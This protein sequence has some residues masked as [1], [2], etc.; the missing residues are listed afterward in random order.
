M[1]S[2]VVGL[3]L[4]GSPRRN[5]G[6][7]VLTGATSTRLKVLHEDDEIL[8]Q[9]MDARPSLVSIDAPL[10][11]PRGRASLEARGP[12]HLRE[13]D[14]ELL[15]RRIPFFPLTLGPM[16]MLTAR[17][18]RLAAEFT[19]RGMPVI[20]SYPGGAQ[21]A[22]GMPRKHAGIEPLRAA[23]KRYGMRGDVE[24]PEI[25]HDELDAVTCALVGR[26]FVLGRA[27]SIG[28]PGEGIMVLPRRLR[29]TPSTEGRPARSP[30]RPP[31]ASATR[32]ES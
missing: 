14:R 3:D 22:L 1:T 29:T 19:G 6:F 25:T 15:R 17:G 8:T 27:E 2:C 21:D 28:D 24:R 16:R 20:E 32:G 31:T 23:L 10:T 9:T 11:L 12:P 26:L 4:A 5:T 18:M 30:R 13:C 7:C